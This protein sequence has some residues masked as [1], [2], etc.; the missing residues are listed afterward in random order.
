MTYAIL[1]YG[2]T[3]YSG[4]LI[5]EQAVAK[6]MSQGSARSSY[7]MILAG[8][9][10]PQL[11]ELASKHGMGFRL[12]GLDDH[13]D[14]VKSLSD[15]DVVINA[16]GPFAWTAERLAKACLEAGSHY[17]DING[18]VDV[19]MRLDD[20][21]RSAAQRNLS[22]VCSAGQCSAVS[23]VFLNIALLKLKQ[24]Q[25]L[26]DKEPLGSIRIAMSRVVNFT[27]GSAQ[28]VAR[29]LRE[30]VTVVR[31]GEVSDRHGGTRPELLLYHEPVGK[32][33]RTFDFGERKA[34]GQRDLRIASAANLVDTLTARL[35]VLRHDLSVR[36]IESY[37]E[38]SAA[39]RISYQLGALLAPMSA[40]PWVRTLVRVPIDLLPAGPTKKEL[41]ADRHL[42]VLEIEDTNRTRIFDERF[43]TPNVYRATA[44]LVVTVAEQAATGNYPGWRTPA[45]LLVP[46]QL[47]GEESD[48]TLYEAVI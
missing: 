22:M 13:D 45:E 27:R 8:R 42:T 11:E 40:L 2:A 33:E 16:A 21:G 30:Q 9:D 12:F 36:S 17:V 32:L 25:R 35:T 7:R 20:L 34:G 24:Q 26:S 6:Q 37:V 43:E 38:T 14:I 47:S 46:R 48:G 19:Y 31:R 29:S 18:E 3:G 1:L 15:V 5:A 39:G 41:D 28:T 23:D 10:G 44:E 4:R